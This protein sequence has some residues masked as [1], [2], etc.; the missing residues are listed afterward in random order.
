[1]VRAPIDITYREFIVGSE[2][3]GPEFVLNGLTL[4]RVTSNVF[5]VAGT[6]SFFDF[7]NMS[8]PNEVY[9]Q[10]KFPGINR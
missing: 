6:A 8:F 4:R 10:A 3:S 1:M 5:R 2:L 9:T 7:A